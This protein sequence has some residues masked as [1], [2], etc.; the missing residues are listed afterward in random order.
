M[1]KLFP[2]QYRL[3]NPPLCRPAH[4]QLNHVCTHPPSFFL[5]FTNVKCYN[6]KLISSSSWQKT[7]SATLRPGDIQ[8]RRVMASQNQNG[9][10]YSCL[11]K[12][13]KDFKHQV[14]MIM[15]S[16]RLLNLVLKLISPRLGG[17]Y[18][19]AV[20]SRVIST[21]LGQVSGQF[22][23]FFPFYFRADQ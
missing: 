13:M 17:L 12:C 14:Q 18:S 9:T 6:D 2:E 23:L 16:V 15:N 10:K 22:H 21:A 5:W 4:Y 8:Y 1:I 7:S 20:A 19:L 3:T 11:S